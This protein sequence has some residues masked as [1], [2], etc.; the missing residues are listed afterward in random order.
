M[1][2]PHRMKRPAIMAILNVTPDSFSDGGAF[3]TTETALRHARQCVSEG[4]NMLD[5]GAE[6]TRP[7]ATAVTAEDEL[8]RIL[9]VLQALNGKIKI[10][11]S[12]DT[13]KASVA[14]AA[15]ENGATIINDVWGLQ[16][17]PAMAD[18]AAETN[19]AVIIMHNRFEGVD[20]TVDILDDMERWFDVSLNLARKSGIPDAKITLDPGIGFGK[21]FRQNLIILA[22]LKRLKARGFPLLIGLS[23]KR[24]IGTVLNAEVDQRLFGTLSANLYSI[25]GGADIIRVHDVKPHREALDIWMAIDAERT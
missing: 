18:V 14:R 5:I 10:P 9:P 25:M 2:E 24:F 20:E 17:D 11:I 8:A 1:H 21:T 13:Y 12:I 7:G 22:H 16:R 3:N 15:T 23:R 4:A 6:S 19:A